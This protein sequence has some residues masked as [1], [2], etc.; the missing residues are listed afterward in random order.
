MEECKYCWGKHNLDSCKNKE[1]IPC[2]RCGRESHCAK[3][4]YTEKIFKCYTCKKKG[5]SKKYCPNNRETNIEIRVSYKFK[6]FH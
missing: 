2:T 4:C 3:K 6:S 1:K 5:H